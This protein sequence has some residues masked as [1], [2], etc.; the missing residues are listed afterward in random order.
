MAQTNA[1]DNTGADVLVAIATHSEAIAD[2][3]VVDMVEEGSSTCCYKEEDVDPLLGNVFCWT[4]A[5]LFRLPLLLLFFPC[6]A[7]QVLFRFLC[8]L[9]CCFEECSMSSFMFVHKT[10]VEFD[11]THREVVLRK[12]MRFGFLCRQSLVREQRLPFD[13]RD[14]FKYDRF[15]YTKSGSC[16]DINYDSFHK[17]HW[18]FPDGYVVLVAVKR[19]PGDARYS[20]TN[21]GLLSQAVPG[22]LNRLT[23]AA[24][25]HRL[26]SWPAFIRR[27]IFDGGD[28]LV[29]D[30]DA[31]G[32]DWN[33]PDDLDPDKV[34]LCMGDTTTTR[35]HGGRLGQ[36]VSRTEG[37]SSRGAN[38]KLQPIVDR[39][40]ACLARAYA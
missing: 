38:G 36:N 18:K 25:P 35:N 21:D 27:S 1:T 28:L 15:C 5:I 3:V 30:Y 2:T 20:D 40:N 23:G 12:F 16:T 10:S 9:R 19:P 26:Y 31:V 24:P 7:V 32:R 39:L 17:P 22:C 14:S 33:T 4:T 13:S 8:G 34:S 29:I 11:Y 37:L 6:T